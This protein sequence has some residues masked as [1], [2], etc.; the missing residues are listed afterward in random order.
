MGSSMF[1][2]EVSRIDERT[3]TLAVIV[4]DGQSI[5]GMAAAALPGSTAFGLQFLVESTWSATGVD[6]RLAA[7]AATDPDRAALLA[8]APT[9]VAEYRRGAATGFPIREPGWQYNEATDSGELERARFQAILTVTDPAY[10]RH[11]A[12]GRGW[13]SP[14]GALFE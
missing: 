4:V 1:R 5:A 7:L 8:A 13:D 2:C 14:C 3:L 11:L 6:P 10:L 12:P 9:F